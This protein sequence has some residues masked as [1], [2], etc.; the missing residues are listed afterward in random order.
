MPLAP[1]SSP[2]NHTYTSGLQYLQYI[3]RLQIM[4]LP[5]SHIGKSICTCGFLVES[6]IL[7]LHLDVSRWSPNYVIYQGLEPGELMY[8]LVQSSKYSRD[9]IIFWYFLTCIITFSVSASIPMN[10][11]S[12]IWIQSGFEL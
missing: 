7:A 1:P 3:Q 8:A 10:N 2:Q 4:G 12:T 11:C 9:T 5:Y 6:L